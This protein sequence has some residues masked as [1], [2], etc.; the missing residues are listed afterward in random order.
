MINRIILSKNP[1]ISI[2]TPTLNCGEFLAATMDSICSQKYEYIQSLVIDGG[3]E[4]NTL[5]IA[6]RY[7]FTEIIMSEDSSLYE[8]LNE[9]IS[10][11][12]GDIICFLNGDDLLAPGI[13]KCIADNYDYFKTFDMLCGHAILFEHDK[14]TGNRIID[15]YSRFSYRTLH[16]DTLL[17]G[18]PIINAHF[19]KTDIFRQVGDFNTSY[20]LAADREF[21]LRC[22]MH[23]MKIKYL[24]IL[25][26]QYRRH[27]GSL[28][29]NR[30]NTNLRAMGLEHMR[31][32]NDMRD[33]EIEELRLRAPHAW[34]DA[35]LT[36][37]TACLRN[38]QLSDFARF[39]FR[40]ST[41]NPASAPALCTSPARL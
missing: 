7:E 20:K 13:L 6:E 9:G 27:P 24:P 12:S 1:L 5:Q 41:E 10:R 16:P 17:Y 25:A 38:L 21:M 36:V 4:D 3:S 33:C 2:I 18:A 34:D 15:N 14:N 31:I 26:Y 39:T 40:F 8:A 35:A 28:T 29:L 19:F 22:Y 23:N 11:S 32:A 37:M 30:K